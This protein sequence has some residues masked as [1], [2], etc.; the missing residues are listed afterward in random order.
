MLVYFAHDGLAAYRY[1]T[2]F[3]QLAGYQGTEELLSC[4]YMASFPKSS[5]ELHHTRHSV[6]LNFYN[7]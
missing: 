2:H 7:N 4:V 6:T 3:D 1:H 5:A